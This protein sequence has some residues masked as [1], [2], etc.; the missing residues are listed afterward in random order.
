MPT[1]FLS[2]NVKESK[3]G[4]KKRSKGDKKMKLGDGRKMI[5]ESEGFQGLVVREEEVNLQAMERRGL[6]TGQHKGNPPAPNLLKANLEVASR[7]AEKLAGGW[8][9]VWAIRGDS[10]AG[11]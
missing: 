6:Y 9:A 4:P 11:V 7:P 10:L 3:Q 8:G 5:R 1:A 2:L